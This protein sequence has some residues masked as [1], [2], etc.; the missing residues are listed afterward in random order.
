[1]KYEVWY[2]EVIEWHTWVDTD[3]PDKIKDMICYG[4]DEAYENKSWV[5]AKIVDIDIQKRKDVA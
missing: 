2:T 1:M 5:N 4:D 3:E